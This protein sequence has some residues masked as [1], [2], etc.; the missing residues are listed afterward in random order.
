MSP[1]HPDT[2]VLPEP[3][4][5][6]QALSRKL[7]DV[8]ARQ[9]PVDGFLPFAD[10]MDRALYEPG[11]GYYSAGLPKLGAEGDFI[12]APELG[13]LFAQC[14]GTQAATIGREL[15]QWDI[16]EFGAGTG[17]MAFD[18]LA[19]LD[20][21]EAPRRYRIVE[22]SADLK[23]RQQERL[24]RLPGRLAQRVEW[25]DTPPTEPWTGVLLANEVLDALPVD[26][27]AWRDGEWHECGVTMADAG[28]GW[29]DRPAPVALANEMTR[30]VGSA[31]LTEGFRSELCRRLPGWLDTATARLQRGV[32][33]LVDYGYPRAEY[34]RAD[35]RQG[36]LVCHYRHRAH[37]D[38]LFWPGLQDITAFVDFTA[39]A[40]A[41]DDCG[42][43]VVGF[44]R[45]GHFLLGAGL[46]ER[47]ADMDT[48][49]DRERLQRSQEV[50]ALTLPGGMGDR[51]RVMALA[52]NWEGALPAFEA[53]NDLGRL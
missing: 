10:F 48:L 7:V 23:Q 29:A 35:R 16:L 20:E 22:V 6:L 12:T 3:P 28:L 39:V 33:L 46:P 26:L 27:L 34:Y 2:S 52:R 1:S 38:P 19:S 50:R 32:A 31:A 4:Q 25:L 24:S 47:L 17:R 21:D 44:T 42:L 51:F 36:T 11:L 40:E 49:P 8:M 15:G 43:E 9:M 13:P 18:L 53:A 37:D 45:Q 41:A 14:L 5:D 30:R